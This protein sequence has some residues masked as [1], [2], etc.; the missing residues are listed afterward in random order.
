MR[1]GDLGI[2]D[3]GIWGF[4]DLV[5]WGFDDLVIGDLKK[6]VCDRVK[7]RKQKLYVAEIR[8]IGIYTFRLVRH[9]AGHGVEY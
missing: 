7:K 5:I 6:L 4:D 1:L 9:A 8:I 2:D 3:L